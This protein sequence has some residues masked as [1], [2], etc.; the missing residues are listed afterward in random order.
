MFHV[1]CS[2]LSQ[3]EVKNIAALARVGISEKEIEKYQK[4]LSAI[5]DYFQ[6]LN[7]LDT[8]DISPI[9]QI[10]G[11]ENISRSDR[12]EDFGDIGKY[13]ILKNAPEL[14]NGQVKVRSVL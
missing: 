3:D 12:A 2:M 9:S 13:D 14:K 10:T 1:P 4:D 8:G 11:M 7:E 6:K 5:L